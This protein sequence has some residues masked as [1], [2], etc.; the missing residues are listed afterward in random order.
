MY[1]KGHICSK[2]ALP[3]WQ[4]M[5]AANGKIHLKDRTARTQIA[6]MSIETKDK[7][8]LDVTNNKDEEVTEQV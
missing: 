6:Q 3:G 2:I 1:A 5:M 7:E 8:E 4:P